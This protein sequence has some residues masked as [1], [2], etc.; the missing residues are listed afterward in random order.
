MDTLELWIGSDLPSILKRIGSFLLAAP[1]VT[2]PTITP[3]SPAL[4]GPDGTRFGIRRAS[5]RARRRNSW[6]APVAW[7]PGRWRR[8]RTARSRCRRQGTFPGSPRDLARPSLGILPSEIK[9]GQ[10]PRKRLNHSG[11]RTPTAV[12]SC[13][14]TDSAARSTTTTSSAKR[15]ALRESGRAR[16]LALVASLPSSGVDAQG[17]KSRHH[18][19]RRGGNRGG[20]PRPRGKRCGRPARRRAR[21]TTCGAGGR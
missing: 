20:N 15:A 13:S 1:D 2:D 11:Q 7:L 19:P 16:F 17:Q 14:S 9:T 8:S 12:R 5:R 6:P 3:L 18:R 4:F 10:F 21:A